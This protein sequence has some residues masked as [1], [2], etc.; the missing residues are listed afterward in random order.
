MSIDPV[1]LAITLTIGLTVGVA[2]GWLVSRPA[3]TRLQSE[4]EKDRAVH[5][6]RL[7]AYQDAEA[8]LR[9]A[10]Q[11]LSAD[12][13][14]TNNEAFLSL[15]E[16]RMREARTEAAGDIDAR[17]KAIED[18]LA[19][20]AK[21]LEQVDREIKDSE[22][23]RVESGAQLMQRIASLDTAGQGLRDETRRLTDA[24]KRPGVR[25][26]WGELQLKRVVELAGMIEYCDFMEQH[27]M[28]GAD[29]EGR[30]RPDVVVRLPGG[31]RIVI[32]AK[33]PL[34]AYLRALEAPDEAA[35][36][37]LL[38]DH[39]RQ[40]R[41]HISQLSAKSYFE[42]I[43][44]TP[45]FVVMFLPGE[46]FFSAA[47]EQ[48]PSLIE[49]GVEKR[50]IPASPTTLIALLRAVAYG[51][52][53]EAMEENAR[54]ISENGRNLYE[55]VRALA[56]RFEKLGRSLK[57]SLEAYNETVGSL[58]GNVLVKARK[59][60]DLQAANG[61]EEIRAL[62]PIDRVPRMLQ[63]AELTDGLPFHDEEEEAEPVRAR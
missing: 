26:R 23:R 36:Q 9:D 54:K 31:K 24:L 30:I 25:G 41:N 19:P 59:F 20:M 56:E 11:A 44:S 37:S 14:K 32:D 1:T 2:I 55:S 7:M 16:T 3:Q 52:Q 62:E 45:E 50:V 15:A 53:Q 46:M 35:R 47:L 33:A 29:D 51:W 49:C 38:A 28:Q 58:E 60:K 34:D 40:V 21:T 48:D 27:T 57:S 18:L 5:A 12:A 17:K 4:L 22:R 42:K 43:A 61:G 8:K 6:E 39:A 13:L 63:A 10:F